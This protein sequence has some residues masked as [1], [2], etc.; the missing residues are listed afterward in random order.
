MLGRAAAT[1]VASAR[2]AVTFA[3][4]S[5]VI[6]ALETESFALELNEPFGIAG[7]AGHR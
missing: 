3:P 1:L 2:I 6:S 4:C 7:H 5:T